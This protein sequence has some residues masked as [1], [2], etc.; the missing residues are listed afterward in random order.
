MN[1]HYIEGVSERS[2]ISSLFLFHTP[3]NVG[4]AI[5]PAEALFF[6]VGLELAGGDSSQVYFGFKSLEGG[7][8]RSLPANFKNLIAYDYFNRDSRSM[9]RLADYAKENRIRLVTMY[10]AQP[11]DPL[12]KFLHEAGVRAIISYW[13][14]TIS[15]RM[16]LWKTALKRL[17]IVLSASK[18][19]GLIFQSKAMAD[20]AIY[21]RGVPSHMIDIVYT[22]VDISVFKP[23][24]SDYVYDAM[25]LPRDKK[26]FVY[27][28]HMEARKGVRTLI[29][30]AIEVLDHRKRHDVC[31]L[32]CGN[33]QDE[34]KQYEQ[35]YAGLGIDSL[36][37]FGGYRSDMPRIYPSC[38]CGVIPTSGWDSFPRSPI[39]M[40]A[41]GLPV[42]ASRLGGL[43]EAVQ[44]RRTGLLFEP[45]MT[46]EL[47]ACIETLLEKP[48][49]AAEYGAR[50]RERCEKELNLENQ[51]RHL[52]EVFLKRLGAAVSP[53]SAEAEARNARGG[54][55]ASQ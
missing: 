41:S 4:Y 37:K 48:E 32:L 35:M 39:E 21:G 15:S 43:P 23:E 50:G 24:R 45:G 38:F 20:L 10:D 16:P 11:V 49:L 26:V 40:A 36:I 2:R 28:G 7:H 25:N 33:K 6:D 13:G 46:A 29:E 54:S 34:S 30:A 31:F 17:Q 5:A 12:F 8:P 27:S 9:R 19:D 1:A 47:V 18:L 44:N 22:G 3:S 14:A 52:R 51:K 55:A 42:I 53:G